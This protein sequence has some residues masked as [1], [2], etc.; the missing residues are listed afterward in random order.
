MLSAHIVNNDVTD[1]GF[2]CAGFAWSIWWNLDWQRFVKFYVRGGPP[3]RGGLEIGFRTFF[4]AC[5]VGAG[6]ELA[7]R[8]LER[9]WSLSFY[10]KTVCVAAVWFAVIIL[11][12]KTVEWFGKRSKPQAPV[13]K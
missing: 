4:A 1:M 9:G 7:E 10:E 6:I 2:L 5:L 8:I 11:M 12:V 13:P 3:Y